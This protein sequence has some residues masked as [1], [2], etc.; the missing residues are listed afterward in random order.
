[1]ALSGAVFSDIGSG[2]GDLF[3]AQGASL[4]LVDTD[5]AQGERTAA[6]IAAHARE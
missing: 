6:A 5:A 2:V 3:A 4:V 1:M